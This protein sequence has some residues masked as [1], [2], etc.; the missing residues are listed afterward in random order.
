MKSI[1]LLISL[2]VSFNIFAADY[3]QEINKFFEL[4]KKDKID[5]AVDSIYSTNEYVS[6][7]PDQ[8][9][10][11]KTQLNAL[12]GMV[13]QVHHI[14][15]LDT[16]LVGESFVYVTY[17]VTYDRQPVRYEFQFFKVKDGWRIYSFSFDDDLSEI[18]SQARKAAWSAKK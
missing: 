8:I 18:Q 14:G 10:N 2:T 1:I 12:K 9:K 17:L 13:G 7:I 11:V 16:F 15:Q 3:Q 4:Y 6:A 5:E